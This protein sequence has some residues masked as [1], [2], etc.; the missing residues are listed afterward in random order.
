MERP[1]SK[2]QTAP[3]AKP[4]P[5]AA[6]QVSQQSIGTTP[7]TL[8]AAPLGGRG[9]VSDAPPIRDRHARLRVASRC[10][11]TPFLPRLAGGA[12]DGGPPR[13]ESAGPSGWRGFISKISRLKGGNWLGTEESNPHV[14]I[15]NL[16]SYH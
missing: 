14:Q 16:L 4:V 13:T 9:L 10:G 15:Q 7:Q 12:G 5:K 3:R 6:S 2:S 8:V 11:L 1:G